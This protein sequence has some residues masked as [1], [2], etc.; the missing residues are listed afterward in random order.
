MGISQVGHSRPVANTPIQIQTM[1]EK[2]QAKI[3]PPPPPPPPPLPGSVEELQLLDYEDSFALGAKRSG[4]VETSGK[5]T[6]PVLAEAQ[7]QLAESTVHVA[8]RLPPAE[9][10][11]RLRKLFDS[12][13]DISEV[14]TDGKTALHVAARKGNADIATVL[15]ET[16]ADP[17]ATIPSDG[18]VPLHLAAMKNHAIVACVLMKRMANPESQDIFGA[19]PLHHAVKNSAD[20]VVSVLVR[21]RANPNIIDTQRRAPLHY[22]ALQGRV[23]IVEALLKAKANP[24]MEDKGNETPFN[25]AF[26]CHKDELVLAMLF[27]PSRLDA[28]KQALEDVSDV[29]SKNKWNINDSQELNEK[30]F[31]VCLLRD[32]P[33]A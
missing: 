1:A 18:S 20:A 24:R 3:V 6:V 21:I 32:L 23:N 22:A 14:D 8:L 31:A 12:K 2:D 16:G 11:I 15:L 10:L 33:I 4:P 17:N 5:K 29:S 28:S 9:A 27:P 7:M 30:E 26:R 19:T 25:I 13:A